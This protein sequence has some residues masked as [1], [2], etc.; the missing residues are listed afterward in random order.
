MYNLLVFLVGLCIGYLV[1][2]WRQRRLTSRYIDQ[3]TQRT[4]QTIRANIRKGI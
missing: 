2:E 4:A 1:S 3:F